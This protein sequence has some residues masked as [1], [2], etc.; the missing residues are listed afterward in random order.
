MDTKQKYPLWKKCK[1]A[2]RK[3]SNFLSSVAE[4]EELDELLLILKE[5]TGCKGSKI[6]S[7]GSAECG[8]FE[9]TSTMIKMQWQAR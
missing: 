9:G 7:K 5:P 4:S 1:G 2:E 6:D 3:G 8:G